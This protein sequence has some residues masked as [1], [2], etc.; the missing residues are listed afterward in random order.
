MNLSSDSSLLRLTQEGMTNFACI[1]DFD[2]KS[3]D[4]L[5][6]VYKNRIPA[7]ESD[8]SN[9]I[10]AEASVAEANIS[11]ILVSRLIAAV[12]ATNYYGSVSR[13]TNPQNMGYESILATFKI[14]YEA[15]VSVKDDD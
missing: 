6:S 8:A 14:E 7:I 15:C 10:A 9:S 13:A 3:I 4:N 2:K 1:S 5:P 11:S 12:N